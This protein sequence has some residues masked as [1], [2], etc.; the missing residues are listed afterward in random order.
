M[1]TRFQA[2]IK[3]RIVE[4]AFVLHRGNGIYFGMT[5]TATGMVSFADNLALVYD[6]GSYHRI[7]RRIA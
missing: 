6:D 3:G 4:Q 1:G 7:G 5:L 2:D